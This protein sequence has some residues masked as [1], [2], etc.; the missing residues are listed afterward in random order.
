MLALVYFSR[1]LSGFMPHTYPKFF[2]HDSPS[3]SQDVPGTM[4]QALRWLKD[5][6]AMGNSDF[7]VIGALTPSLVTV[8][9]FSLELSP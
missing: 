2:P 4:L 1:Q 6:L 7:P 3:L 9:L 8:E 5:P